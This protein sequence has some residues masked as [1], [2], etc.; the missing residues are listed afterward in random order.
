[1]K[2]TG[3]QVPIRARRSNM[4]LPIT[5]SELAVIAITPII[6][7][8]RSSAATG[9]HDTV[10]NVGTTSDWPTP[11]PTETA[12]FILTQ[13]TPH[14][15]DRK[16]M[17]VARVRRRS[18][19]VH[20]EIP[21]DVL[22]LPPPNADVPSFPYHLACELSAPDDTPLCPSP[23]VARRR[24]HAPQPQE[25]TDVQPRF[26]MA[27]RVHFALPTYAET[28]ALRPWPSSYANWSRA[29]RSIACGTSRL[30]PTTGAGAPV[31]AA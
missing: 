10:R 6:G 7:C 19:H 22:Y 23:Q 4:E 2:F 3:T 21:P 29:A 9:P 31:N 24:D 5:D 17:L 14:A 11:G 8:S 20:L 25:P 18:R 13:C 16:P 12:A 28:T 30:P 27:T 15:H 26:K 1:M